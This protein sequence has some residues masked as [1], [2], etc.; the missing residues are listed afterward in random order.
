MGTGPFQLLLAHEAGGERLF[1]APGWVASRWQ[2]EIGQSGSI[3][4]PGTG[5][6]YPSGLGLSLE[7]HLSDASTLPRPAR[8]SAAW[9]RE[10]P[11]G[12]WRGAEAMLNATPSQ[13]RTHAARAAQEAFTEP[14]APACIYSW[15]RCCPCPP[16]RSQPLSKGSE[17]CGKAVSSR[18]IHVH[19][20]GKG[21]PRR[22]VSHGAGA[23]RVS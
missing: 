4:A 13:A 18:K 16:G 20:S 22:Q 5:A 11:W 8:H 3:Y 19:A 17:G 23:L 7:R 14:P 2:H 6:F 21:W 1:P 12:Q 10:L 15:V 9:P